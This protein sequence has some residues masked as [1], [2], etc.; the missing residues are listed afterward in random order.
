MTGNL[1]KA[2]S[3][4]YCGVGCSGHTARHPAARNRSK[5]PRPHAVIGPAIALEAAKLFV[6]MVQLLLSEATD[7]LDQKHL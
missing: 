3:A 2:K 6:G 7:D 1:G 5:F 4:R